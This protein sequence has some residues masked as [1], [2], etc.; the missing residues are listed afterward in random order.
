MS[1]FRT[2]ANAAAQALLDDE[3]LSRSTLW[4]HFVAEFTQ[5]PGLF[6]VGVTEVPHEMVCVPAKALSRAAGNVSGCDVSP[7]VFDAAHTPASEVPADEDAT[8]AVELD[9]E[10]INE[11]VLTGLRAWALQLRRTGFPATELPGAAEIYI[12]VITELIDRPLGDET[13]DAIR[14]GANT[15]K[16][17]IEQADLDGVPPASAAQVM[18]VTE[19]SASSG[20]PSAADTRIV[21]L[22]TSTPLEYA[23]GQV[24]PVMQADRQGVWNS[25]A[26]A[27]P[28]NELGQV[29]FHVR[30]ELDVE[31][32]DHVTFG[33]AYGPVPFPED[34]TSPNERV[35][36]IADGTGLA[37]AKA[38]V[39]ELMDRPERPQVELMI[40]VEH[41]DEFY[42]LQTF[43]S[44]ASSAAARDW[45]TVTCVAEQVIDPESSEAPAVCEG[46]RRVWAPL[47]HLAAATGTWW[48][49]RLILC[50]ST[51]RCTLLA[52]ALR[53]AGAP[54][55]LVIAPDAEPD[56][57]CQRAL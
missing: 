28:P 37:A 43:A 14:R 50:G 38:M 46:L 31:V 23:A 15:M 19:A 26:P 40:G 17:A 24:I 47:E 4:T 6:P 21:R 49:R 34:S 36:L 27:L 7:W 3:T 41:E 2:D 52:D 44:L 35:L 16:E 1:S 51:A 5:A 30:D 13:A 45:L 18:A 11:A 33:T 42:D 48:G 9:Q 20:S 29:E 53:E 57:F 25:L 8:D 54:A 55:P 32:G 56:W 12:D 39:F 10:A 22:E